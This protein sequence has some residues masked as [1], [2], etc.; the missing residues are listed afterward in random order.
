MVW[1]FQKNF[2]FAKKIAFCHL[3]CVLGLGMFSVD[4]LQLLWQGGLAAEFSLAWLV[5]VLL[6]GWR[7]P[8]LR[9]VL[10]RAGVGGLTLV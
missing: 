4:L 2:Q 3:P 7:E 10:F 9:V 6:V 5:I 1:R 8:A